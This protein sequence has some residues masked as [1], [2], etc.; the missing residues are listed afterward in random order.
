[1][2]TTVR[3]QEMFNDEELLF[4]NRISFYL[5]SKEGSEAVFKDFIAHL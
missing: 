3:A 4:M 5:L 1:M 2:P